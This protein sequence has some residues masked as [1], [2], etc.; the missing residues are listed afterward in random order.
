MARTTLGWTC[1][2]CWVCAVVT[3][4]IFCDNSRVEASLDLLLY[5][6]YEGALNFCKPAS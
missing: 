4:G 2:T 1:L 3:S 6:L 5:L